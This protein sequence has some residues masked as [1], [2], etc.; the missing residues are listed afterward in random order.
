M[1]R[2][3]I[4]TPFSVNKNLGEAYNDEMSAIPDG[5]AACLIDGDCMFTT[6]D[7]GF[8]LN[9]YYNANPSAVLTCWINRIHPLAKGQW[10]QDGR[11]DDVASCLRAA[12]RMKDVYTT[13]PIIG[14]VSGTLLVVPKRVWALHP[15]T[16]VNQYRPGEPNLLGVDNQ[17]T[18]NVRSKGIPVLRMDGIL[19]YHQYRLLT[20]TKDHLL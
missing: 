4:R 17:F 5:D 19:I 8:R 1:G 15:F 9:T 20:N 7:Y 2:V 10:Y 6:S 11:C 13:T 18:N 12:Q 16:L 14:S 3:W